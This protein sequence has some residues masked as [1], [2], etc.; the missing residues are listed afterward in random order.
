MQ[1]PRILAIEL[2]SRRFGFAVLEGPARLVD[3]GMKW[4][5]AVGAKDSPT[6][7]QKKMRSMLTLFVPSAVIVKQVS[8][9][10]GAARLRNKEVMDVIQREA[11]AHLLELI[12]LKRTHIRRAFR[13]SGKRSKDEIA[14]LIAGHF[15]ELAWRLPPRRKNWQPEHHNMIIFDAVS[16]GL[17]YLAQ[18]GHILPSDQEKTL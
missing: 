8:G 12:L 11:E 7:V 2:R 14:A 16:L 18:C 5:H 15:P 10:R 4:C 6:A 9:A 17:A 3:S 13:Q 1:E